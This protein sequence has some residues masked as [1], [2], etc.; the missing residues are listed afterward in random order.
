MLLLNDFK[1]K[2]IPK[3]HTETTLKVKQK[4]G[5]PKL[6]DRVKEERKLERKNLKK[7][8][9]EPEP[10]FKPKILLKETLDSSK[11]TTSPMK[12]TTN[13]NV[14]N[15]EK[16]ELHLCILH[17]KSAEEL[18]EQKFSSK[19][20]LEKDLSNLKQVIKA[21]DRD[22]KL[23]TKADR[24]YYSKLITSAFKDL[25]NIHWTLCNK[26]HKTGNDAPPYRY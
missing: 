24:K 17:L 14:K 8:K 21:L 20:Y 9:T 23:K 7:K 22:I 11:E 18:I 12:E 16:E 19:D 13:P 6:P 1:K 5:R 4:R 10:S 26:I 15:L 25:N 2:E 3:T